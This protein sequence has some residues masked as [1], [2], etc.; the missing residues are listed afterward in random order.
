MTTSVPQVRSIEDLK[1]AMASVLEKS[2]EHYQRTGDIKFF[3]EGVRLA[4]MTYEE[5]KIAG[6]KGTLDWGYI[7]KYEMA[8]E[9]IEAGL[10]RAKEKLRNA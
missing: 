2:L 6:R 7:N 9:K 10:Q 4:R 5:L 1:W 3:E 8:L